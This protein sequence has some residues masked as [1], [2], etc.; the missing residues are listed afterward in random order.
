[1][2][3]WTWE[4]DLGSIKMERGLGDCSI[5]SNHGFMK[6]KLELLKGSNVLSSNSDF[7]NEI[8]EKS[9]TLD[10]FQNRGRGFYQWLKFPKKNNPC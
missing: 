3:L 6:K 8:M 2:T 10:T 4:V 7:M 9:N 5:R 1:M